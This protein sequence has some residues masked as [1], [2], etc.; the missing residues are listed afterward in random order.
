MLAFIWLEF[1]DWFLWASSDFVHSDGTSKKIPLI[2]DQQGLCDC[3]AVPLLLLGNFIMYP[4]RCK[5]VVTQNVV[6]NVEHSFVTYSDFRCLLTR[7]PSAISIQQRSK[8]FELC[9][10]PR[11]VSCTEN[12]LIGIHAFP[13]R[14]SPSCHYPVWY[15]NATSPH[16]SR[17]PWK[18]CYILWPLGTSILI[19]KRC[20]NFVNMVLGRSH[21]PYERHR[22]TQCSRLT[23]YYHHWLH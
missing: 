10:P 16:T 3:I 6:Q 4:M 15:G 23:E 5:F 20:S 2:P 22:S 14:Y 1:Q 11:G 7:G 12:V 17:C 8:E 18:Y 13:E 19:Q 21:Y 9:F